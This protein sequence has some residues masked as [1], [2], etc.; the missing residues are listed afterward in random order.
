V[1]E[2][3]TGEEFIK[4]EFDEAIAIQQTIVDAEEQL[5]TSHPVSSAKVAIK[6]YLEEDQRFLAQLTE[7]GAEHGATGEAEDVAGGL[8][9]L[10]E[11]TLAAVGDDGADSDVYEA[12]AVLVNLKRKQMDSAGGMLE[13]ARATDDA[14]LEEAATLFQD[15]QMASAQALANQLAAYAVRIATA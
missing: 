11:T 5:S 6:T 4:H 15:A 3:K 1:G 8:R 2:S 10:M 12:H 7:L 9:E 13:I 14:Q